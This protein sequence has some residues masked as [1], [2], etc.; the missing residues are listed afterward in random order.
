MR[1]A[2]GTSAEEAVERMR[3]VEGLAVV[4]LSWLF[5]AQFAAIPYRLGR[6]W[7]RSTRCSSRCR[8]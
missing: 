1:K 8:A 6:G 4:S 2:G 3:R 7:A 5:I